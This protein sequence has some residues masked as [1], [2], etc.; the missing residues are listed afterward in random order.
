MSRPADWN[1]DG[2]G[3]A[4]VKPREHRET[5]ILPSRHGHTKVPLVSTMNIGLA[6]GNA[7]LANQVPR[8]AGRSLATCVHWSAD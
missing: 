7:G 8:C 1:T 5:E 3:M 6:I 2:V 4:K